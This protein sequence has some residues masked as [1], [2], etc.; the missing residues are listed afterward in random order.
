MNK[1]MEKVCMC[2]KNICLNANKEYHQAMIVTG[3][4]NQGQPIEFK[5][6]DDVVQQTDA[7]TPV[8]VIIYDQLFYCI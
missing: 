6:N 4:K 5:L 7:L 2:Y 1:N 8:E 3:Q